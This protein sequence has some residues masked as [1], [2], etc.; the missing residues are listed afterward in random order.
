MYIWLA[1]WFEFSYVGYADWF[2]QAIQEKLEAARQK[3]GRDIRVFETSVISQV[4]FMLQIMVHT[5]FF[6]FEKC[7]GLIKLSKLLFPFVTDE[8]DDMYEF[9]PED[10]YRVLG[11]KKQVP[12]QHWNS[13]DMSQLLVYYL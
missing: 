7:F 5:H 4:Q 10:Y 2:I 6:I 3:L 13:Q 11:P 1:D 9:T 12:Y 8:D